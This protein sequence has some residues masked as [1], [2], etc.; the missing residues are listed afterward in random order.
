M[1]VAIFNAVCDVELGDEV[2]FASTEIT[3]IIDIRTVHYLKDQ[4]V[5]F[6]FELAAMPGYWYKR[7]DFIYPA[8]A[9]VGF[10]YFEREVRTDD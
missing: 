5:E 3:E 10:K 9:V 8:V 4:R 6:E 7:Q 2:R 1:R